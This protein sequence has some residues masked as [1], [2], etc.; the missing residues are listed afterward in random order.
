[1]RTFGELLEYNYSKQKMRQYGRLIR[2]FYYWQWTLEDFQDASLF[3]AVELRSLKTVFNKHE[4][5]LEAYLSYRRDSWLT[6]LEAFEKK[7]KL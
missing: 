2:K 4:D 1:M 3:D 5:D 7:F 6:L